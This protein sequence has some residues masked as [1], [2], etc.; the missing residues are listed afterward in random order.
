MQVLPLGNIKSQSYYLVRLM[1]RYINSL[2][3]LKHS[4]SIIKVAFKSFETGWAPN[5][6]SSKAC[7]KPEPGSKNFI[8][9]LI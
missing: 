6:C 3:N 2:I 4:Y 8:S 5:H 9:F 7:I 1:E